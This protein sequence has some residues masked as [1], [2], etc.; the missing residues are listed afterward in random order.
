MNNI[1]DKD[2]HND[3]ENDALKTYKNSIILKPSGSGNRKGRP[4]PSQPP[5]L[6]DPSTTLANSSYRTAL[7]V[8]VMHF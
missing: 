6:P 1:N 5:Q 4:S 7:R 2:Y 3:K 8:K